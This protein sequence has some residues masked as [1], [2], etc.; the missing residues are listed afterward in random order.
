MEENEPFN[1]LEEDSAQYVAGYICNRFS[2]KYP[3]LLKQTDD[4]DVAEDCWTNFKSRGG[5]KLP[6]NN[7]LTALKFLEIEFK[8]VNGDNITKSKGIMKNMVNRLT[9]TIQYLS[10]PQEVIDCLVRTRTFIRMNNL[11]KQLISDKYQKKKVETHKKQ[12]FIK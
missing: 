1:E 9:P 2:S 7:L 4:S 3:E 6:S 10:I 5:L 11:N 12:K 8:L